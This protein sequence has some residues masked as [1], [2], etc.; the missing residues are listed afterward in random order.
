MRHPGSEAACGTRGP[1]LAQCSAHSQQ[2]SFEHGTCHEGRESSV[3]CF[4]KKGVPFRVKVPAGHHEELASTVCAPVAAHPLVRWPRPHHSRLLLAPLPRLAG[5]A[6]RS[7]LGG[8]ALLQTP[9]NGAGPS[10]L[11]KCGFGG[12]DLDVKQRPPFFLPMSP[13][14]PL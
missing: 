14:A 1:L 10:V 13:L 8:S 2:W 5:G 7:R 4:S 3:Y 6:A 12:G 11:S 9:R